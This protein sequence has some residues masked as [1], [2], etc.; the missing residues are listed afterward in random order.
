MSLPCL[1]GWAND[2]NIVFNP[3]LHP[4][5]IAVLAVIAAALAVFGLYRRQRGS[6][7]RA[8][9]LALLLGALVNP[10][11]MNED[12]E[13]LP[14]IVAIA[15]DRSQSQDVGDRK[16]QTDKAVEE[17]KAALG[18]F[19]GIETRVIDAATDNGSATPSTRLF[20][21]LASELRPR[22]SAP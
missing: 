2:M 13:A 15:A 7:L 3:L 4:A 10:V 12:R 18:R 16:N 11:I 21:N 1:N 22:A 20:A 17:L 9:A 19:H 8:I 5:L 14:T 6:L